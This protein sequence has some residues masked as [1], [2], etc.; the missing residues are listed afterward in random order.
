MILMKKIIHAR[1]ATIA[2]LA[3][4]LMTACGG[5]GEGEEGGGSGSEGEGAPKKGET[6]PPKPLP[7]DLPKDLQVP[8]PKP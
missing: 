3:A 7:A 2:L 4:A 1:E 5:D 8:P 6:L